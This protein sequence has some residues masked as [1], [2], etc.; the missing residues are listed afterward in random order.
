MNKNRFKN[1]QK[2]DNIK[3]K[4]YADGLLAM[5][6]PILMH[7]AVACVEGVLTVYAASVLGEFADSVFRLDFALGMKNVML[8]GFSLFAM[9][10][11]LPV[12]GLMANMLMLKYAL[13]HDRMIIGRFLDKK[14]DSLLQYELGDIQNRLDWDPTELRCY[15]VMFFEKGV[16]VPVTLTFLLYH[17]LKL[18]PLYTVVVL[19]LSLLML[20]VPA[21]VKKLEGR[22]EKEGREYASRRRSLETEFTSYPCMVKLYGLGEAYVAK[23]DSLYQ[24]YFQKTESRSIRLSKAAEA[25][26]SFAETFCLLA[27]LFTGALL[28]AEG[29]ITLGSVAAMYG[30]FAVFGTL[31]DNIGYLVRKMPVFKN[32]VERLTLFYEGAEEAA[33]PA[34][35][36]ADDLKQAMDI[37]C[38]GFYLMLTEK[39]RHF[40]RYPFTLKKGK[41]LLF[42]AQ[43]E[44]ASLR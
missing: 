35:T 30:Y 38:E 43:M 4:I 28:A 6:I 11:L 42:A 41:K 8:L 2:A 25:A 7:T 32:I 16:M 14:Y 3:K 23:A 27:I 26:A 37:R 13:V 18:S 5:C 22:Y 29:V 33:D 19:A 9:I 12:L 31:L 21:A 34:N 15:L 39:H 36:W 1:K 24:A 40:H 20:I 17:A 10:A 44:A